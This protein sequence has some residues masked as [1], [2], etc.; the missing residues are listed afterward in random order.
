MSH[1]AIRTSSLS[2]IANRSMLGFGK[3]A[4]GLSSTVVITQTSLYAGA[5]TTGFNSELNGFLSD[6]TAKR[7]DLQQRVDAALKANPS[8]KGLRGSGVSLAWEYEYAEVRMGGRGSVEGG[9]TDSEIAQMKSDPSHPRPKVYDPELGV[10]RT[11]E[12]HH[13]K[14]VADHPEHQANPDNIRIYRTRDEHRNKGHGGSFNNE[15][16]GEFIDRDK[17]L[18]DTNRTRVVKN[19]L[20]GLAMAAGIGFLVGF[21]VSAISELAQKGIKSVDITELL[22]K[23]AVSGLESAALAAVGYG[24]SR[25]ATN[26]LTDLGVNVV[27]E[28]GYY[29]N[30]SVVGI[31]SII[32]VS[33]YQYAKLRY[34]GVER[35]DALGI[36]L[37]QAA[38]SLVILAVSII[39]Q[40]AYGGAAGIIVSTSIGLVYL[41]YNV[42][43][44]VQKRK[45]EERLRVYT[46]EQYRRIILC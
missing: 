18:R 3:T 17:R 4:Q 8:F 38:F 10:E 12:G 27:S 11:P 22:V 24:V 29:L 44:S 40:G 6:L 20:Q 34:N 39:V 5:I 23:S 31:T 15:S 41:G 37:K 13:I 42:V 19:E 9:W 25:A 36:V 16:D 45:F 32:L 43:K 14:N 21:S 28:A 46:I 7:I 35:G 1:L 2:E 26:L 33:V 30:A